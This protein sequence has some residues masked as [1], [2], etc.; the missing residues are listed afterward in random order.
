[1]YDRLWR[2]YV[3]GKEVESTPLYGMVNGFQI[4]D[5]GIIHIKL[6]YTLQTYYTIGLMV[7]LMSFISLVTLHI[8]QRRRRLKLRDI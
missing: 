4:N 7:S 5:T 8:Y 1:P 2:A 6:Y 3:N